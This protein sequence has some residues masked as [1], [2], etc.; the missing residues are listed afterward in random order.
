M[1]ETAHTQSPELTNTQ[2][3]SLSHTGMFMWPAQFSFYLC[4]HRIPLSRIEFAL[5]YGMMQRPDVVHSRSYL[6]AQLG[7]HSAMDDRSIDS[8]IKRIRKKLPY[9]C[10]I[11]TVHGVGYRLW[12]TR[13]LG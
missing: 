12:D 11:K 3:Q 8:H 7:P 9:K 1:E 5:M 10:A 4:G 6:L 13:E 2:A